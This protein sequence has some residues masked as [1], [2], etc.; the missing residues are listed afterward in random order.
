ME[1]VRLPKLAKMELIKLF[2]E[3]LPRTW[4]RNTD[5]LAVFNWAPLVEPMP[6]PSA[7]GGVFIRWWGWRGGWEVDL[8][9]SY[10]QMLLGG[11]AC[12]DDKGLRFCAQGV[13]LARL[14]IARREYA[15]EDVVGL[16]EDVKRAA[17]ARYLAICGR[18]VRETWALAYVPG[19]EDERRV[20]WVDDWWELPQGV[21]CSL[22]KPDDFL[23][24]GLLVSLGLYR[25]WGIQLHEAAHALSRMAIEA[26]VGRAY[27]SILVD[28][29]L[30]GDATGVARRAQELGLS[31]KVEKMPSAWQFIGG[32]IGAHGEKVHDTRIYLLAQ[33]P[34]DTRAVMEC[35][36]RALMRPS[37]RQAIEG[38]RRCAVGKAR[39]VVETYVKEDCLRIRSSTPMTL[40]A[41][42]EM[43][44]GGGKKGVSP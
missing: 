31:V 35:A 33:E 26:L 6:K 8:N 38:V 14:Y 36:R 37:P 25:R 34:T 43:C 13:K 24:Y 10:V 44:E 28:S 11:F 12:F 39:E 16:R 18:A 20:L 32:L 15:F 29:A 2:L 4:R 41:V 17:P 3:V 1:G 21:E 5:F 40:G 9:M 42:M 19:R 30:L 27:R 7:P 23:K 22:H